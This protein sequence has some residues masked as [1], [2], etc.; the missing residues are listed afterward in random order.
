MDERLRGKGIWVGLGVLAIVFL[1]IM[2]CG[3]GAMFAGPRSAVYVQP[4]VTGEDVG[5]PPPP[6][7]Y[8]SGSAGMGHYGAV[9]PFGFIFVVMGAIFRLAFFGLL[10]L[11][12]LGLLKRLFFGRRCWGPPPGWRPPGDK[13]GAGKTYAA[14]G[15]RAW[16]VPAC[17]VT[18]F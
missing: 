11:L 7:F 3:M 8:G 9:G 6:A 5:A 10:L 13:E 17:C 4:P 18:G 14:W 2:M 1:C 16:P 12:G 15:P